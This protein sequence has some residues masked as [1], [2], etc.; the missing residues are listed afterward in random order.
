MSHL[1]AERR[2]IPSEQVGFREKRGVDVIARLTQQVRDRWQ[3]K[4]C[5]SSKKQA[6]DG[7]A[8]Q[9][10]VLVAYDFADRSRLR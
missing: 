8:V 5:P 10:Y 6:P 2:I 1:T 3:K 9:K 7:E 4:P